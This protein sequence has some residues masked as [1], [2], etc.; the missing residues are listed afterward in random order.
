MYEH[1]T[2][3]NVMCIMRSSSVSVAARC[4]A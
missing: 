1:E 2:G 3:D 4:K